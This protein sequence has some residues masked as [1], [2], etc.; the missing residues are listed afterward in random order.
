MVI[1]LFFVI[2]FS[3]LI[4]FTQDTVHYLLFLSSLM[5]VFYSVLKL[6]ALKFVTRSKMGPRA[7]KHDKAYCEVTIEI[8]MI[9]VN[10]LIASVA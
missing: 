8:R 7:V 5:R 4:L 9:K 3:L 2:C 6:H 1:I 10:L